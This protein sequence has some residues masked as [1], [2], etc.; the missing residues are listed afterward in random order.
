[1]L[2]CSP[3]ASIGAIIIIIIIVLVSSVLT[4]FIGIQFKKR[5]RQNIVDLQSTS[6]SLPPTSFSS[7]QQPEDFPRVH[8]VKDNEKPLA[9]MTQSL[10]ANVAG[11]IHPAALETEEPRDKNCSSLLSN[12]QPEKVPEENPMKSS[13]H[14]DNEDGQVKGTLNEMIEDAVEKSW[15]KRTASFDGIKR[16][17]KKVEQRVDELGKLQISFPETIFTFLY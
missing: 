17:V 16:K 4:T 11:N 10:P 2:F 1:M 9:S 6:E 14:S 3:V 12:L 13:Y 8:G 15:E 7:L 5:N